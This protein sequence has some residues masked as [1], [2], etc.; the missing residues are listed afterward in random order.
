[1]NM[2][3]TFAHLARI[4]CAVTVACAAIG[5]SP[6]SAQT[7]LTSLEELRRELAAGDVIIVVPAVGQAIKGRLVRLGRDNLDVRPAGR[8]AAPGHGPRDVTIELDAVQSLQRPRD[9]V[10]NGAALGAGIGAGVGGAMFIHALAI[11][12]NELNEWA[13]IYVASTAI[14]TGI[15]A[16]IGWA[17]DAARSK[18]DIT[19]DAVPSRRTRVSVQPLVSRGPGIG[20]AVSISR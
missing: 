1:M 14:T 19:Y 4:G 13:P 15:G 9:S 3:V 16:L 10:K 2:R 7:R 12:R 5:G 17:V 8:S 18:P 6:C 11:D 20:V